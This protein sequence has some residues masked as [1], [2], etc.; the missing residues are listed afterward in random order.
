MLVQTLP[1]WYAHCT[2]GRSWLPKFGGGAKYVTWTYL[3]EEKSQSYGV[4]VKVGGEGI[5]PFSPL[6]NLP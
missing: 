2:Q 5:A 3:Y 6:L 4:I 1:A